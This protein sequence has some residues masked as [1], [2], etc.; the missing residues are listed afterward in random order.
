VTSKISTVQ[1]DKVS[2]SPPALKLPH[3]FSLTPNSSGKGANLQKR[4]M[5]APQTI[6][7]ENLSERNSLDQPL[8]NNRLDNPSQGLLI[9]S[10][11][12]F[13][14]SAYVITLIGMLKALAVYQLKNFGF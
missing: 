10:A 2:A 6:Q 9:L 8:S 3:L 1:L 12:C 13:I 11:A 14:P 5:L 4:Q 7:M